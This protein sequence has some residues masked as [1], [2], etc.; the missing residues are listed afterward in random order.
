MSKLVALCLSASLLR[1]LLQ[2]MPSL[3]LK[4]LCMSAAAASAAL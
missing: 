1:R 3:E 4:I 2:S